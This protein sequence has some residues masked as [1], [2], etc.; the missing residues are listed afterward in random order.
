[1]E[2]RSADVADRTARLIAAT[3]RSRRRARPLPRGPKGKE[4]EEALLLA[5]Q[6]KAPPRGALEYPV[7]K[8]LI[9][10]RVDKRT[11]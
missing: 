1:M 7:L 4:L 11:E 6:F 5:A 2:H 3:E 8:R 10:T 9:E